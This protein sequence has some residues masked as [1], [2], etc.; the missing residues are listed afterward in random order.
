MCYCCKHPF[1]FLVSYPFHVCTNEANLQNTQCEL[2]YLEYHFQDI[3]YGKIKNTDLKR[4][5]IINRLVR[6]TSAYID[7]VSYNSV[8]Y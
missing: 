1:P 4:K 8:R 6:Q 7:K 2:S 3:S 5:K